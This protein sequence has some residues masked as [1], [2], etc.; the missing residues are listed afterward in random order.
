MVERTAPVQGH[1]PIPWS[2]HEAAWQGYASLYGKRQSAERIAERGGFGVEEMDDYHPTWREE[3]EEIPRMRKRI[4]ALEAE[5]ANL[6]TINRQLR[7]RPDLGD[8]ARSV[9]ALHERIAELE[10]LLLRVNEHH[11]SCAVMEEVWGERCSERQPGCPN[12]DA[13]ALRD[14][15]RKALGGES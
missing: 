6:V 14:D 11:Q 7:G 9:D 8:R 2:V 13:Y 12:C 3:S 5:K 15:V 1:A 10:G 4:A